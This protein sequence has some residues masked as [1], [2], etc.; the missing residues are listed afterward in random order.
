MGAVECAAE[1]RGN[2]SGPHVKFT[3]P[4]LSCGTRRTPLES[5]AG[6]STSRGSACSWR[7]WL[8]KGQCG[9]EVQKVTGVFVGVRDDS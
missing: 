5:T 6:E 9:V 2:G 7:V 8:G 1:R 3:F 4:K